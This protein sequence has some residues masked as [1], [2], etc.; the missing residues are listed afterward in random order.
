MEQ[1]FR[2]RLV[3]GLCIGALS[4]AACGDDDDTPADTGPVDMGRTDMGPRDMGPPDEDMGADEDMGTE[5]DAGPPDMGPPPAAIN[6]RVAHLVAN[7][8]NIK[9]CMSVGAPDSGMFADIPMELT[10]ALGRSDGLPY[11]GIA[12]YNGAL[13]EAGRDYQ[14]RLFA[15]DTLTS[16]TCP[17]TAADDGS[18][19]TLVLRARGD[20]SGDINTGSYYTLAATGLAADPATGMLPNVCGLLLNGPCMA[21][22]DRTMGQVSFDVQLFVDTD[23]NEVDPDNVLVSVMGG[24]PNAPPIKI[25]F[26]PDGPGDM[27]PVSLGLEAVRFGAVT[28]FAEVPMDVSA[29]TLAIFP[30]IGA[31]MDP[32]S[33][34][35]LAPTGPRYVPLPL[36]VPA[37]TEAMLERIDCT[38][39]RGNRYTIFTAGIADNDCNMMTGENCTEPTDSTVIPYRVSGEEADTP[40]QDGCPEM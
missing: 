6:V 3:F 24:S 40:E 28:A 14:L 26:D 32:S 30:M 25:C 9:V 10:S 21:G 37:A 38:F 13:F 22:T 8:P 23:P 29:G 35:T 39:T 11:R 16:T 17:A 2:N 34:T 31:D 15:S 36:P 27:A 12:Y 19:Y 1:S 7:G 4:L 5:E 33:C 18:L 20:G